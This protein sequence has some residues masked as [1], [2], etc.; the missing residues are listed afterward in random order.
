MR[1]KNSVV[2]VSRILIEEESNLFR[3]STPAN[4]ALVPSSFS[5][6]FIFVYNYSLVSLLYYVL[7]VS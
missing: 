5:L 4:F 3:P 6:L 1:D 7:M 2:A